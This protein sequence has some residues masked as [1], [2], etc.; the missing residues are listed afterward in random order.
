MTF[1]VS[2]SIGFFCDIIRKQDVTEVAKYVMPHVVR[3][4]LHTYDMLAITNHNNL[5]TTLFCQTN[6]NFHHLICPTPTHP[7][8]L[9]C[10]RWHHGPPCLS[11]I[12]PNCLHHYS[13][14]QIDLPGNY[15]RL[16]LSHHHICT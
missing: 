13:R 14:I 10:P 1:V 9:R 11:K 3:Y 7:F 8:E 4:H 12:V 5:T 2:L 16:L 6:L 15:G